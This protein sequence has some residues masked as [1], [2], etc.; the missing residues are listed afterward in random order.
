VEK[1][2]HHTDWVLLVLLSAYACMLGMQLGFAKKYLTFRAILLSPKALADFGK[3]EE[4]LTDR[5]A[6][7][8][9]TAYF[10]LVPLSLMLAIRSLNREYLH[11]SDWKAYLFFALAFGLFISVQRVASL[12]FAWVL[13]RTELF[14]EHF[15]RR[16]LISQWMVIPL[17]PLL[18]IGCFF[19]P[20]ATV[21]AW[22]TV[23]GITGFQVFGLIKS[24]GCLEARSPLGLG[25][26]LLYLCASEIAPWW[27]LA[28]AIRTH[29][30]FALLDL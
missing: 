20:S 6:I 22:I 8:R 19:D 7:L 28:Q 13:N 17:F 16:D 2:I 1:A 5:F 11:A 27:F 23:I 12:L 21:V 30:D 24:L 18:L 4:V 29:W 14:L 26:V 15:K 10:S 25:L 9:N 3:S